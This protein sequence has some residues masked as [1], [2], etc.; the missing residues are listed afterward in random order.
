MIAR[1]MIARGELKIVRNSWRSGKNKE[2]LE[3]L[4]RTASSEY[5]LRRVP[6]IGSRGQKPKKQ[7]T[8][9]E[10]AKVLE[11]RLIAM[12]VPRTVLETLTNP[13]H[14]ADKESKCAGSAHV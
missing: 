5:V 4:C 8:A 6:K 14:G 10:A 13:T 3:K 1:E 2:F 9:S 11:E 12:G 7:S